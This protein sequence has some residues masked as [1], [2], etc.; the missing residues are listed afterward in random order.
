[1]GAAPGCKERTLDRSFLAKLSLSVRSL[2]QLIEVRRLRQALGRY[3]LLP[4]DR[5]VEDAAKIEASSSIPFIVI[6]CQ[7][8][9]AHVLDVTALPVPNEIRNIVDGIHKVRQ[10]SCVDGPRVPHQ[11]GVQQRSTN[12]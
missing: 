5:L 9:G 11:P 8:S 2:Y 10:V 12:N 4:S 7:E 3:T 1:M 6:R